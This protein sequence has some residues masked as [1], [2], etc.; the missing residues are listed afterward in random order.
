MKAEYQERQG[1]WTPSQF[2]GLHFG[3]ARHYDLHLASHV[4]DRD[5]Y[6]GLAERGKTVLELGSGTG[7]IAIPLAERGC[8]VVG[9]ELLPAMLVAAKEKAHRK[10]LDIRWIQG[11]FLNIPIPGV[12][13]LVLAPFNF[14]AQFPK[15]DLPAAL[16]KTRSLVARGGRIIFDVFNAEWIEG[17]VSGAPAVIK[18]DA[19]D[20]GGPIVLHISSEMRGDEVRVTH[21]YEL[22]S[23]GKRR[24]EFSF[25]AWRP[26]ELD[27][28]VARS[29]LR[30]DSKHGNFKGKPF[31]P[32]DPL[33]VVFSTVKW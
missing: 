26:A 22:P 8:T 30:L 11:D 31:D 6:S 10:S 33:Q 12:F 13:D 1:R 24:D 18:Y 23:G 16:E 9:V 4:A 7:R 15:S 21:H 25:A 28:I 27:G 29:G 20:G 5:F 2:A 19:P 32:K 14:F 3:D 17:R